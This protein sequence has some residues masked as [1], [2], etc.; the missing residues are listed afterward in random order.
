MRGRGKGA[1]SPEDCVKGSQ[2]T[3]LSELLLG[4]AENKRKSPSQGRKFRLMMSR[5]K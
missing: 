1:P 3:R 4:M 5:A 2:R